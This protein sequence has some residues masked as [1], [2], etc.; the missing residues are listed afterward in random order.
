MAHT[1]GILAIW[2]GTVLT[3]I[4]LAS[5]ATKSMK[6]SKKQALNELE[7]IL[8]NSR[9]IPHV[10]AKKTKKTTT[11]GLAI[12]RGDVLTSVQPV[13]PADAPK[14]DTSER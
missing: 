4:C 6:P 13:H 12:R 8:G 9:Y 11:H 10:K 1:L 14:S 5:N 7:N 3:P 2:L